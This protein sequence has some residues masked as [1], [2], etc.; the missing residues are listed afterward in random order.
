VS[1]LPV[2]YVIP[3][4]H[5]CRAGMLMLTHKGIAYRQVVLRTGP[6]PLSVRMRGFAGH[7]EPIRKV[8]GRTHASLAMLDRGGTVPALRYGS[9]RIQTNRRIARFL[10]GEVPDP[11][12]LPLDPERRRDVEEAERWGD[13][14]LQMTARR[15]LLATAARG[16]YQVRNR[17]SDGR[18]GA[19]LARGERQRL[20]AS[21]MAGLF[22]RAR[23]GSEDQLLPVLPGMLDRVDGWI[24]A[25]VL[26]GVQLNAADFMIAPSLAL[27]DYRADLAAEIQRRPCGALLDR[28]LPQPP[29]AGSSAGS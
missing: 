29:S 8:D 9:E 19:L 16:L 14:V 23:G 28:V 26:N 27:L 4:S 13:E 3:G 18:L 17:G 12:L 1:E 7:R 24:A 6:H 11:P 15:V 25:G 5:A 2:L 10:D 22:F 21:R 20:L